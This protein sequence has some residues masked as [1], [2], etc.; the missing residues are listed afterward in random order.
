MSVESTGAAGALRQSLAAIAASCGV[1][2]HLLALD[3]DIRLCRR[4]AA[5]RAYPKLPDDVLQSYYAT[6][7]RVS[8]ELIG[9][10]EQEGYASALTLDAAAADAITVI[11]FG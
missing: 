2:C 8:A 7:T 3:A 9:V 1:S 4:R 6:W 11:T 5:A 10:A